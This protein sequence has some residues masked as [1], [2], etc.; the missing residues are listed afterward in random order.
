M[1][2]K[3]QDLTKSSRGGLIAAARLTAGQR[4]DRS[5]KAGNTTLSRF[6]IGYYSSLG[7]LSAA[8]RKKG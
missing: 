4:S 5:Q 8:K 7:K 3:K 2:G 1:Q 6:G